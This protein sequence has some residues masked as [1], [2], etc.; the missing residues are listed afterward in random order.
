MLKFK[1]FLEGQALRVSDDMEKFATE[2][3]KTL[4]DKNWEFGQVAYEREVNSER[5]GQRLIKVIPEEKQPNVK[6]M[7]N[8]DYL[9]GEIRVFCKRTWH[10]GDPFV[11]FIVHELVHMFDPKLNNTKLTS[12]KWGFDSWVA[13][14]KPINPTGEEE[15]DKLYHTSPWEQDAF[16]AQ[17]AR[18]RVKLAMEFWGN[19]RNA[20]IKSLAN[21][22]PETSW[23]WDFAQNKKM[24]RKYL[25]TIYHILTKKFATTL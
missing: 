15:N 21:L 25:N 7:G 16:M 8:A 17:A 19:D 2:S 6:G 12:S 13:A 10:M 1:M 23:E 3:V 18:E 9:T 20:I 11:D 24:W 4:N 14:G 5:Y 22:K